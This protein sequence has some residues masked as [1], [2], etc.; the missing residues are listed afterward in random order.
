MRTLLINKVINYLFIK[1]PTEE[2]PLML[3]I[4]KS[5]ITIEFLDF[6]NEKLNETDIENI[7]KSV[8]SDV[9]EIFNY[10]LIEKTNG[11]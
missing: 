11:N 8:N 6:M 5:G 10:A 3:N 7:F 9:R 1:L 2:K 4:L